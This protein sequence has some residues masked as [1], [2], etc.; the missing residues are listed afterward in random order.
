MTPSIEEARALLQQGRL[1]ELVGSSL[2]ASP[3]ELRAACKKAQLHCHPDKGGDP[4]LFRIVREAVNR[5]TPAVLPTNFDG[6]TPEWARVALDGIAASRQDLG[7][8]HE[9]M[10]RQRA[11]LKG[12]R[13]DRE[14]QDAQGRIINCEVQIYGLQTLITVSEQEYLRSFREHHAQLEE[15]RRECRERWEAYVRKE[16]A[17]R[18]R[19]LREGSMLRKRALAGTSHRFPTL[20]S[21]TQDPAVLAHFKDLRVQ[22]RRLTARRLMQKRR[23]LERG[24]VPDAPARVALP[25]NID[26]EIEALLDSAH[27]IVGRERDRAAADNYKTRGL[28]PRV[29]A[30]DPR[31]S[32]MAELRKT[33]Q[34]LMKRN[35]SDAVSEEIRRIEEQARQLLVE[36]MLDEDYEHSSR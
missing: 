32:R 30:V 4:E 10:E 28:F 5:L 15:C 14:R 11:V 16:T 17:E 35:L 29:V 23:S 31:A 25:T 36:G 3:D 12:C 13:T 21:T 2:E 26:S 8:W 18:L 22:Y 19:L 1:H 20:P 7:M 34:K 6:P 33:R 9:R 27:K 24:N